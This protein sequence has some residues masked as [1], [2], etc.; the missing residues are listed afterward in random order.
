MPSFTSEMLERNASGSGSVEE[1][2]LI[3]D[4]AAS[5]FLG[6]D[7][8]HSNHHSVKADRLPSCTQPALTPYVSLPF[9][10]N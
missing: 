6:A 3:K 8:R 9:I 10:A 4:V 2:K 5:A 1:E 7:E